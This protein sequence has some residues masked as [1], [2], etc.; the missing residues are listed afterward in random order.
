MQGARRVQGLVVNPTRPRPRKASRVCSQRLEGSRFGTYT[1]T[2]QYPC[3]RV[4]RPRN[5]TAGG[6]R[7]FPSARQLYGPGVAY[8]RPRVNASRWDIRGTR[9]FSR[10]SAVFTL[11]RKWRRDQIH[12]KAAPLQA[13]GDH[14]RQ[15]SYQAFRERRRCPPLQIRPVHY[16]LPGLA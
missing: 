7:E 9:L 5:V 3:K 15:Q 16:H 12:A 4:I 10:V 8:R 14:T 1:A 13:L 11:R 6:S 2:P